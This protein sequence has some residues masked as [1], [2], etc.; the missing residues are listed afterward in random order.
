MFLAMIS[1]GNANNEANAGPL[2]ANA[3]VGASGA[4]AYVGARLM[5]INLRSIN[6]ATWQKIK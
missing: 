3:Y 1:G 4:Y 6:P 2:A 5:P